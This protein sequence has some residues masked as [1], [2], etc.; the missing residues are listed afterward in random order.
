[1]ILYVNACVRSQS[2][3]D[4][5]ARSLLSAFPPE[6]VQEVNLQQEGISP[7]DWK[8]LEARDKLL[9]AGRL[10]DM[11]FRYARQFALA[12]HI[13]IAA[14]YWDLLFPASLRAYFERV[15]VAGVTFSYSPQGQPQ[16]HCRAKKLTYV[17]TAGG[18][19]GQS[20]LGFS[21]LQALCRAFF[22][23]ADLQLVK[24]EGLDIAG[25][26]VETILAE[27]AA[28]FGAKLLP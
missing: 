15:C 25:A 26:D 24:A 11:A 12:D 1:M 18:Y 5:L 6:E 13:V 16:S 19:I 20:H 4:R 8:Q 10:D 21:Y 9:A 14:P 22:G 3:T 7:L 2:R 17:T 23:I 27:A 28:A